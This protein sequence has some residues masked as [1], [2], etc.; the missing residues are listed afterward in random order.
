MPS[1]SLETWR[2]QIAQE[3]AQRCQGLGIPVTEIRVTAKRK[4]GALLVSVED[5]FMDITR[6]PVAVHRAALPSAAGVACAEFARTL[7]DAIISEERRLALPV[8][9]PDDEEM[10]EKESDAAIADESCDNAG[11]ES[12]DALLADD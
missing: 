4:A 10:T 3:A 2:W 11:F 6:K 1:P 9:D 5:P 7:R 8:P 12:V